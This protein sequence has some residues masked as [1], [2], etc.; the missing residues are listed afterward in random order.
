MTICHDIPFFTRLQGRDFFRSQH[1]YYFLQE[2]VQ[3]RRLRLLR[4]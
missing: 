2:G 3:V 1:D 4:T